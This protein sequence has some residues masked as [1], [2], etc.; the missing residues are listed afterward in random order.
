MCLFALPNRAGEWPDDIHGAKL[1]Q[2]LAG[3]AG[4][5]GE[6]RILKE[7]PA[8]PLCLL[9]SIQ[10]P[11]LELDYFLT[12]PGIFWTVWPCEDKP[13]EQEE[14]QRVSEPTFGWKSGQRQENFQGLLARQLSSWRHREHRRANTWMKASI[15]PLNSLRLKMERGLHF[16]ILWGLGGRV[17]GLGKWWGFIVMVGT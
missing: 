4:L 9:K 16:R 8:A 14:S 5:A 1:I 6:K 11:E 7:K 2:C 17:G 12:S 15:L 13:G 3:D 10:P